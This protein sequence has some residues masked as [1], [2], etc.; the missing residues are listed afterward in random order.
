MS[1]RKKKRKSLAAAGVQ[2]VPTANTHARAQSGRVQSH[3]PIEKQNI[4]TRAQGNTS[5]IEPKKRE[6]KR[7]K[8]TKK[9]ASTAVYS[10][11]VTSG[12]RVRCYVIA[13]RAR[14]RSANPPLRNVIEF[15][16]HARWASVSRPLRA[17]ERE[18]RRRGVAGRC[19]LEFA[20]SMCAYSAPILYFF[21]S[22]WVLPLPMVRAFLSSYGFVRTKVKTTK[23][24]STVL[25]VCIANICI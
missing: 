23:R 3:E 17:R 8:I 5:P 13:C 1:I 6:K 20:R 19:P 10:Y 4:A 14:E 25:C 9:M 24:P 12:A 22:L 2:I 15:A 7:R 11:C 16:L 18:R 21:F